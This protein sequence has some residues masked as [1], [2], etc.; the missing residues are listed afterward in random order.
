MYVPPKLLIKN[1]KMAGWDCIRGSHGNNFKHTKTN[2][3]W[4]LTSN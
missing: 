1:F 2:S 4:M 3:F